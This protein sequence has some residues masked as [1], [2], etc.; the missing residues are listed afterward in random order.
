MCQWADG[1]NLGRNQSRT[2]GSPFHRILCKRIRGSRQIQH[3]TPFVTNFFTD[4]SAS[5]AAT[6]QIS[7]RAL[8]IL[9]IRAGMGF[10]VILVVLRLIAG[11]AVVVSALSAPA[12]AQDV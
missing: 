5:P 3:F 2:P 11:L 8:Y 9:R 7:D 6:L 1:Q 12:I 4:F 10:G